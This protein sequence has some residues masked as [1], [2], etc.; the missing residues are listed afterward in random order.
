[1][2]VVD[3]QASLQIRVQASL[4]SSRHAA[5]MRLAHGRDCRRR[6]TNVRHLAMLHGS[7]ASVHGGGPTA[8]FPVSPAHAPV[9]LPGLG[10]EPCWGRARWETGAPALRARMSQT[11]TLRPHEARRPAPE[12]WMCLLRGRAATSRHPSDGA[13]A[14]ERPDPALHGRGHEPVQGPCSWGR[15]TSA[16]SSRDRDDPEVLP[17]GRPRERR[18][19][20]LGISPS[21]RCSA[22]S[23]F[24]DYF[25]EG[26]HSAGR[27]TF[28]TEGSRSLPKDKL[29]GDRLRRRRR[30]RGR[31]L[32]EGGRA[33]RRSTSTRFDAKPRTSG[34]PTRRRRAPTGSLRS[35][36]RD[37]LRLRSGG[38]RG[39]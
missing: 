11:S 16:T 24:G 22:T 30:G 8:R 15:E 14:R 13:R 2:H 4:S 19:A 36:Q 29:V 12:A 33:S 28:L 17:P 35:L 38:L 18:Q 25:K 9:R 31:H 32:A 6:P 7:R 34:P 27:G 39:R 5:C 23:A 26:R 21:S 20:R 10:V 1:M 3:V 37:L